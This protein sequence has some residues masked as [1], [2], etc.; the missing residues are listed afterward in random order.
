M[1]AVAVALAVTLLLMMLLCGGPLDAGVGATPRP[2]DLAVGRQWVALDLLLPAQR[3]AAGPACPC[4]VTVLVAQVLLALQCS[5]PPAAA[6]VYP[7]CSNPGQGQGQ[8]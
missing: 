5:V 7:A 2:S 1:S 8:G 3:R 4:P 6:A